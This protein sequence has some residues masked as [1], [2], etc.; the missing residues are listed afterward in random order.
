M[1]W[2]SCTNQQEYTVSHK[3]LY[4]CG[5]SLYLREQACVN[6]KLRATITDS[7]LNGSFW[8]L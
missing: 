2:L 3:H 6:A 4:M 1:Q 5:D 8:K 7:I